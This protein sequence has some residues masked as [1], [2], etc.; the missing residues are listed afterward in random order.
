VTA[1]LVTGASGLI[2]SSVC[3]ALRVDGRRVH[4]LIRAGGNTSWLDALD[5]DVIFG[6]ITDP[7]AVRRAAE[8]C[9]SCVHA[10]ALVT[11][12]PPYTWNEYEA[13]NVLGSK[14]VFEAARRS[15]MNRVVSFASAPDP[16]RA[17]F[18]L[19][20]FSA[21]PYYSTKARVSLDVLR[22]VRDGANIVEINPGAT[23]GAA[24]SG[25]RAVR[26]PGLNA[27]IILAV[28]GE[29]PVLPRYPSSCSLAQDVAVT[30]CRALTTGGAGERFE[31]AG[32]VGQAFDSVAL[33]EFAC[34]EAGVPIR[35]R[36]A[37]FEE[38]L[39]P[40]TTE[41]FGPSIVS[42]ARMLV[43]DRRIA[44]PERDD[45]QNALGHD[46]TPTR[47]AVALTVAWMRTHALI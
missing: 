1:V 34:E 39:L 14:N 23:F 10:A 8:G 46:P 19:A 12:G 47:E 5:I 43:D 36:A 18:R 26:P 45:S 33:L 41:Q 35:T 29:L 21:D 31:L 40:A 2:G 6:D 27:R 37:T 24:P 11:G 16:R 13:V 25:E 38:L 44:L 32:P 9:E 22:R 4:A 42:A 15:S 17:D 30:T 7:S 20:S 3:Q 28:R